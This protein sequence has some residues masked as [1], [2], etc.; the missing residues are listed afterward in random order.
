[1]MQRT[2]SDILPV[3]DNHDGLKLTR[4]ALGKENL[5]HRFHAAQDGENRTPSARP[6][7][8]AAGRL[9]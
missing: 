1:M 6:L 5:A 8:M 9:R 4:H 7:T 3:E 2:D